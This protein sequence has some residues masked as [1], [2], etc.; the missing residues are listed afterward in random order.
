MKKWIMTIIGLT[1]LMLILA[2]C[3]GAVPEAAPV[4]QV[5]ATATALLPTATNT[6][7]PEP[8]EIGMEPT[9]ESE[10]A[11]VT[12]TEEP[13]TSAPEATATSEPEPP[14][15]PTSEPPAPADVNWLTV[16]GK[17]EAGF[18]YL[19]NPDAPVTLLDYSD[20]M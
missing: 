9:A 8:T 20:F 14:E 1:W 18:T 17:T 4:S 6:A 13:A 10:Q 2:A 16:E 11:T 7:L 19:G 15:T 3:G 5:E 12:P